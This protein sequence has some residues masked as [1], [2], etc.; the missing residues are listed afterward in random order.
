MKMIIADNQQFYYCFHWRQIEE[1]LELLYI[2]EI[3]E[4][5]LR[6]EESDYFLLHCQWDE[7]ESFDLKML[8]V[9]D[10]QW[11]IYRCF[12]KENLSHRICGHM[13]HFLSLAL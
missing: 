10:G 1:M 5:E 2:G 7:G 9:H 6:F 13:A 4:L 11:Q 8:L 3:N 12:H